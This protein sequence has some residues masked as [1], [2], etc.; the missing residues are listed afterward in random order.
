MDNYDTDGLLASSG[1]EAI[2]MVSAS[3][4]ATASLNLDKHA[5]GQNMVNLPSV[6]NVQDSENGINGGQSAQRT[7]KRTA[8]SP[9]SNK[10][11]NQD[12]TVT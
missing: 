4:P 11:K 7:G 10:E 1:D 5:S 3:Q 12:T 2:S 9:Q 8:T 6:S